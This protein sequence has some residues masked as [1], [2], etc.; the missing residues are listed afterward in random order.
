MSEPSRRKTHLKTIES[1]LLLILVGALSSIVTHQIDQKTDRRISDDAGVV[2]RFNQ[3]YYDS[4]VWRR[5]SYLGIPIQQF[6]TDLWM[7]QEILWEV[8]PDLIVETGTY[9]GGSTLF[10]AD[11]LGRIN[12]TGAVITV[13][14]DPQIER[15]GLFDSFKK[16]VEVFKGDSVSPQI[17]EAIRLRSADKKVLV[18]LDSLHTR[19][20]VLSELN[21]YA[22]LVSVGSYLIVQDTNINGHPVYAEFG[23]GPMEAVREF[24]KTNANFE[25]DPDRERFLLTAYPSG[26]LKRM[27]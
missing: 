14:I 16:R 4:K 11:A 20:H 3:I 10:F 17:L 18:T 24:L 8:K 1:V 9:N 27:K 5:T 12:E 19:E 21:A 23:P 13:D 7:I 22:P 26:F 6:P 15:S 2:A 25:V